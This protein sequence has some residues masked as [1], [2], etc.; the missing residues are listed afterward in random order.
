MPELEIDDPL[1]IVI[2]P[3]EATRLSPLVTVSALPNDM[4]CFHAGTKMDDRDCLWD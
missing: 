3:A 1:A 2:V 4:V